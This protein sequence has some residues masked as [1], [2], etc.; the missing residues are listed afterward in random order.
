MPAHFPLCMR[1]LN[2]LNDR[3][4]GAYP[5]HQSQNQREVEE[6]QR[7]CHDICSDLRLEKCTSSLAMYIYICIYNICVRCREYYAICTVCE[8][9]LM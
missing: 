3:N 7:L 1:K 6:S 9:A 2:D 4:N 8:Y 5:V